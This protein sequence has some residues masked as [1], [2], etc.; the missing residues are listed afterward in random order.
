MSKNRNESDAKVNFAPTSGGL[1][2]PC[3]SVLKQCPLIHLA[4]SYAYVLCSTIDD[5]VQV[6]ATNLYT[7]L[8]HR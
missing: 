4:S 8:V 3:S 7:S 5:T 1:C 6:N 2:S